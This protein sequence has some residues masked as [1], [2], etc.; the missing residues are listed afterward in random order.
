MH[1]LRIQVTVYFAV[2]GGVCEFATS[3]KSAAERFVE[4][5]NRLRLDSMPPAE[6]QERAIT[7]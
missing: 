4:T 7:I 2:Q 5:F 1:S 6:I 3:E